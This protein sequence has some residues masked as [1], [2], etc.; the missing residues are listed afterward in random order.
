[1]REALLLRLLTMYLA[2]SLPENLP[3]GEFYVLRKRWLRN[4]RYLEWR[5]VRSGCTAFCKEKKEA[6]SDST[7]NCSTYADC[8][9]LASTPNFADVML[10][11][12]ER[13]FWSR[14]LWAARLVIKRQALVISF[15][16][17]TKG[18]F[19]Q[20]TKADHRWLMHPF[21]LPFIWK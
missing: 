5:M 2:I 12:A 3:I 8:F 6:R 7:T 1:M 4:F 17:I 11:E 14:F 15:L 20:L 18:I 13:D 10:D 16:P 9:L 19:W 21:F